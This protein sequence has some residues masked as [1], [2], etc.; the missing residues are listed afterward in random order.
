MKDLANSIGRMP[1]LRNSNGNSNVQRM[2]WGEY[3]CYRK[4]LAGWGASLQDG[5]QRFP[6]LGIHTP[7]SPS[8]TVLGLLQEIGRLLQK[9]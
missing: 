1:S 7:R 9:G 8:H 5:P 3:L 2:V 4:S 6:L